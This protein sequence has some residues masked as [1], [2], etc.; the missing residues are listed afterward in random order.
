MGQ[1]TEAIDPSDLYYEQ[2]LSG[3]G[4]SF[5][6]ANDVM[7]I[8]FSN[9]AQCA[10]ESQNPANSAYLMVNAER[11]GKQAHSILLANHIKDRS[12]IYSSLKAFR[13]RLSYLSHEIVSRLLNGE[14][15]FLPYDLKKTIEAYQKK[16]RKKNRFLYPRL[17]KI[18]SSCEEDMLGC[19]DFEDYVKKLWEISEQPKTLKKKLLREVDTALVNNYHHL[20]VRTNHALQCYYLKKFSPLQAHLY[21]PFASQKILEENAKAQFKEQSLVT[22][23]VNPSESLSSLY[24]TMQLDLAVVEEEKFTKLGF[25]FWHSFKTYLDWAW[26][27]DIYPATIHFQNE[28]HELKW[29]KEID[30]GAML[31]L[32]PNG[33]KSIT[34]PSCDASY[35]AMNS[36][37]KLSQYAYESPT[38]PN[39]QFGDIHR[40][41]HPRYVPWGPEW[42]LVKEEKPS[43]NGDVLR[44][45]RYKDSR[46][47]LKNFVKNT[48]RMKVEYKN[49]LWKAVNQLELLN[50]QL[51][52]DLFLKE[53]EKNFNSQ[54]N[55]NWYTK[56]FYMCVEYN[57]AKGPMVNQLEENFKLIPELSSLPKIHPILTAEKL[58]EYYS[59]YKKVSQ[60]VFKTCQYLSKKNAFTGK[61][62][63]YDPAGFKKWVLDYG[64]DYDY[65]GKEGPKLYS[66][67][68]VALVSYPMSSITPS[69]F[70]SSCIDAID[71]ARMLMESMVYL[72]SVG[73]YADTFFKTK[74]G[75]LSPS[76][77]NPY[78]ERVACKTYDPWKRKRNNRKLLALDLLNTALFGWNPS[79]L[80]F[81][82]DVQEGELIS[83]DKFIENGKIKYAAN[84][85]KDQFR[86]S[87]IAHLG[88][89][90]GTPCVVAL[91]KSLVPIDS[92]NNY[93]NIFGFSGI[94]F[95]Y[96]KA[97]ENRGNIDIESKKSGALKLGGIETGSRVSRNFTAAC[98]MHFTPVSAVEY[99][100]LDNADFSPVKFGVSL[101]RAFLNFFNN[102]KHPD[103][104]RQKKYNGDQVRETYVVDGEI[105]KRCLRRLA[106]GKSCFKHSCK[107]EVV[108]FME[109]N[110]SGRIIQFRFEKYS[111]KSLVRMSSCNG[112]YELNLNSKACF[113][114]SNKK[115]RLK[116][117]KAYGRCSKASI[118][119]RG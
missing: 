38:L 21:L 52:P 7:P 13:L 115:R 116:A 70:K 42:D 85:T 118:G 45:L 14:L 77:F 72:Y 19:K 16:G 84:M 58:K 103:F 37:R 9:R 1:G 5:F 96:Q 40:S 64:Q 15:P 99:R 17:Q 109:E 110:F 60:S 71:C 113:R 25:D 51:A 91:G 61:G 12:Y 6:S 89:I 26:R 90:T 87:L 62:H 78:A 29:F 86:A 43:V 20:P 112:F 66:S 95:G 63:K 65:I 44:T 10:L 54:K 102:R 53:L 50:I 59:Y 32:V 106:Q 27:E 75:I 114:S 83:F 67:E 30:L 47:W 68:E 35:L 107:E 117:I 31:M 73:T 74:D 36:V 11:V 49:R 111:Y 48:Q 18:V 101:L 34:K 4:E 33:C 88:P 55:L 41:D 69:T 79:P 104:P 82:F 24:Y 94:T 57:V 23:C 56:F 28:A 97:Y 108:D 80:F 92:S 100:Q 81:A 105:T 39:K 93:P 8:V 119:A 3:S 76:L 46:A 22:E 98:T 2:L